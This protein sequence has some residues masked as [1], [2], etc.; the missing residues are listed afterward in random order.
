MKDEKGMD[1]EE[2]P[3][4]LKNPPDQQHY[5]VITA[6][7]K[8]G[9]WKLVSQYF[10]VCASSG[11]N[12]TSDRQIAEALCNLVSR[13]I[14][15]VYRDIAPISI[16]LLAANAEKSS[17][18]LSQ[19]EVVASSIDN[20]LSPATKVEDWIGIVFPLL[21]ALGPYV[22]YDIRLFTALCRLIK[23]MM[24]NHP[25]IWEDKRQRIRATDIVAKVFLII[26]ILAIICYFYEFLC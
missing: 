15:P 5:G 20:V 16:D 8:H 19:D 6:L 13:L 26:L 2:A 25:T 14:Y 22:H 24:V 17:S 18:Q 10:L 9:V 3:S 11:V 23:D 7:I 1:V 12:A 21:Q 4:D